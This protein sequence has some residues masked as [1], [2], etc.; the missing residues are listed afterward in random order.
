MEQFISAAGIFALTALAAALFGLVLLVPRIIGQL[1]VFGPPALF[2]KNDSRT[3]HVDTD[4]AK[5]LT[6]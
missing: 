1:L 4:L 3:G 2:K 6:Q 5:G